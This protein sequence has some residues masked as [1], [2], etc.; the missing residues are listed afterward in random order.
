MKKILT[1]I[2]LCC[3]IISSG[4]KDYLDL[5]PKNQRAVKSLDDLKSVLAGYLDMFARSN[6]M[7]IVG[8]APIMTEGQNMMFEAYADNFDFAGNMAQYIHPKNIHGIEKL[9]ANKLLFNDIESTD[10]I[11]N[12]YYAMIGFLNAL[13]DQSEELNQ[14]D[15]SELKRVKGEMLVHRAYYI[16]KLQQYFAPMDKEDL[17]IPL[18]LHTGKE[19]MG[20]E[21]KRQKS[22]DV[23]KIITDDLKQALVYYQSEGA[24]PGYS[25]FFNGR[26]IQNLLAQV[27]WF[28]AASSAREQEDYIEAKNY[29]LAAVEGVDA[30]IPSTL[31]AFQ[32]VQRNLDSEYPAIYMQ[33]L[34]FGNVAAIYG[35]PYDYLGF[36]PANLKVTSGFLESFDQ[37]DI[38]KAAYF[39]GVFLSSTWPDGMPNGP[40]YLRIHLFKPEEAYLILAESYYRLNQPDQALVILNKFKGLRGATPKANLNGEQL[41]AE[42]ISER[43]KEF[44]CDTDKRWLDLKRYRLETMERKLKFFD[45]EFSIKVEAGDYHYALPIPLTELQENPNL[46][47]NAGWNPIVF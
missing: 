44:F 13:I 45:K 21:M 9:Y 35:S 18:Y 22:A 10:Y 43:R 16:F 17:G 36:A 34:N 11:W 8:Q 31:L 25:R 12:N 28:K 26:F 29:A 32:N 1:Y 15:P 14:A 46:V 37:N 24:N 3:T 19:V 47:P 7:P 30:Y 40:K 42:I 20:I 27:Y 41:L 39:N 6:T 23:Y 2:V 5:P 38:R 33:S 4:C